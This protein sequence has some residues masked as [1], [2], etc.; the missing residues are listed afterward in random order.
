[1][2][3]QNEVFL[4]LA[5]KLLGALQPSEIDEIVRWMLCVKDKNAKYLSTGLIE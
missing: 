2:E 4:P 5:K 1:M 3:N